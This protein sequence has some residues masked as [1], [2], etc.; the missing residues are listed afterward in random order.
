MT[1]SAIKRI[2]L[3][4]IRQS[5]VPLPPLGE[6]GRIVEKLD[7][8]LGRSRR[9][10]EELQH[11]PKL[12]QRYKQAVLA[13]AFRGDL[14]ADWRDNTDLHKNSLA[15]PVE[16]KWQCISDIAEVASNLVEPSEVMDLPHIA[17]NHIEPGKPYLLPFKTVR[18]D[19]VISPK[20]R[21]FP[22]QII[23]S[24]IRPYLRKAVI[25]TFDG[26]CS[27]DMYPINARCNTKYLLYWLI[28]DDFNSFALEYQGR[29]VLPKIN[30]AGLY[31]VPI[32]IPS[33]EEQKEI[34]RRVEERFKA[35]EAIE[36]NYQNAIQLLDRLDQATLA[37]AFRG[38]LVPQDPNDEPASVLLE[39]I[40]AQRASQPP[41]CKRKAKTPSEIAPT[42]L[43]LDCP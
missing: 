5:I 4:K 13:A 17:P 35:I 26:V 41:A 9:A 32:P 8:L 21:F 2:V 23:Y 38:Q 25:A 7:E 30:Q 33:L 3:T 11:I 19:G 18:E 34:V 16:W 31:S 10:R 20:H 43:R 37:K 42:Q 27:A 39:R 1:G 22:G 24:K 14:T 12:I 28:S 40:R 29:T 6:Q 15:L 36:Q